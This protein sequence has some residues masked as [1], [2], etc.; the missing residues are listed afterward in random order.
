MTALA[1]LIARGRTWI[2]ADAAVSIDGENIVMRQRAPKVFRVGPLV[3][4]CA[5]VCEY[6][7]AWRA[8]KPRPMKDDAEA[9]VCGEV[10]DCVRR[11]LAHASTADMNESGALV[12]YKAKLF[13]VDGLSRPWA[14]ADRYAAMGT[15]GASAAAM[16]ALRVLSQHWRVL[17][18]A[19]KDCVV[20]ALSCAQLHAEGVREPFTVLST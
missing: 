15:P 13:Y 16:A 18:L 7:D 4:A 1:A 20:E 5:G 19:P 14:V 2:G 3:V 11:H 6:E 8:I 9:W 10:Y 12:G 17:K